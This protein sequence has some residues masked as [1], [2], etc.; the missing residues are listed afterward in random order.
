MVEMISIASWRMSGDALRAIT[1]VQM[2]LLMKG[3]ARLYT[4]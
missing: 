4:L 1:T 2:T 3:R